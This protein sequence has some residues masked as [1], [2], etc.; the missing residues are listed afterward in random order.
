MYVSFCTDN[1]TTHKFAR[2]NFVRYL[3]SI[4]YKNKVYK[5]KNLTSKRGIVLKGGLE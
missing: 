5:N 1:G 3:N 2:T 4:G